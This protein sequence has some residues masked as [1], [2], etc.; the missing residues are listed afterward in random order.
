MSTQD[1]EGFI[2]PEP[3]LQQDNAMN[4]GREEE[5]PST[6]TMEIVDYY[7][8]ANKDTH[9]ERRLQIEELDEWRAHKLR[10]Y[11]KLK[12]RQNKLD[13]SPNQLQNTRPGTRAC[14]KPWQTKGRD[15]A[16]RYGCVEAGHDFPKTQDAI[17]PHGRA[18]WPW[19]N[20]I[21]LSAP[22]HLIASP[23]S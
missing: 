21:D 17:N 13:T 15:T 12:L 10:T 19:V 23:T 4:K 3:K 8:V 5:P 20:F 9:E 2:A 6:K 16:I 18:T 1:K 14:L 11:D 7:Q 22:P